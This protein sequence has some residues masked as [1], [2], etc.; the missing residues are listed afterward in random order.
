MNTQ[1]WRACLAAFIYSLPP[2]SFKR[3]KSMAAA[4]LFF[5]IRQCAW[6]TPSSRRVYCS[7]PSNCATNLLCLWSASLVVVP[8]LFIVSRSMLL[9]LSPPAEIVV[10]TYMVTH[11]RRPHRVTHKTLCVCD[12]NKLRTNMGLCTKCLWRIEALS[13]K[14]F[15]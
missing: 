10:C 6:A 2:L 3:V 12:S 4:L 5:A 7:L 15:S 14:M 11:C 1:C 8:R 9:P 13:Y